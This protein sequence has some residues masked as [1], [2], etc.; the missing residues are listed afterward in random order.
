MS[1]D[2]SSAARNGTG[3]STLATTKPFL[4]DLVP[5]V[6]ETMGTTFPELTTNPGRV[7]E[8]IREDEVSFVRTLSSGIKHFEAAAKKARKTGTN[9]ILGEDAFKLHDTYG[10]YIDI[11]EQMAAEAGLK[12]DL[13][14]FEDEMKQARE[15]SAEFTTEGGHRADRHG[16]A[17]ANEG[18]PKERRACS[19]GENGGVARQQQGHPPGRVYPPGGSRGDT[20]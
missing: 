4:C 10:V 6:V 12:V 5:T 3:A 16:V 7:A 11:T 14:G 13:K 8:L 2:A 19:R 18:H 15:R 1:C 9:L 17:P 20:A